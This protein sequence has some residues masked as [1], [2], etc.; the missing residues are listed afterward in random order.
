MT[1]LDGDG[2][3]ASPRASRRVQCSGVDGH[4]QQWK[5]CT[6]VNAQPHD[7]EEQ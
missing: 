5:S 6:S 4:T 1:T 7:E 3:H 2:S